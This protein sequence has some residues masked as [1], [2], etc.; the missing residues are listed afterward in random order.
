MKCRLCLKCQFR[1][2]VTPLAGVWIEITITYKKHG[3]EI[4]TPLAGV[5][6]E[7]PCTEILCAAGLRS[8]PSREC[9]LKSCGA[10]GSGQQLTSLPSRECGLKLSVGFPLIAGK[11]VTPLAGVWIEISACLLSIHAPKSHSPRGSVD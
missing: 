6:I 11:S 2:R 8:L 5:W 3:I 4:V 10:D 1:L 7:I 9:G